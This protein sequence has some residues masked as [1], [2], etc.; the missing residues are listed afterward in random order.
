MK[1]KTESVLSIATAN[2]YFSIP[3]PIR[4]R[5]RRFKPEKGEILY[6]RGKFEIPSVLPFVFR[7]AVPPGGDGSRDDLGPLPG[8]IVVCNGVGAIV[9]EADREWASRCWGDKAGSSLW[10]VV[11][12]CEDATIEGTAVGQIV[13]EVVHTE[14]TS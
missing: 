11:R 1:M 8:R 3:H 14:P 4:Q 13:V 6:V 7:W 2:G 12:T 5:S 9:E 10:H